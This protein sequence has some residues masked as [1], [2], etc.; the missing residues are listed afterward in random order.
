MLYLFGL[1]SV[2][3]EDCVLFQAVP[4]PVAFPLNLDDVSMVR[5]PV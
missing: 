1:F 3:L 5:D 2:F 4:E